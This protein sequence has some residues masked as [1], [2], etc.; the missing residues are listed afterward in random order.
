MTMNPT[1][2]LTEKIAQDTIEIL[3]RLVAFDTT[4]SGSNLQLIEYVE[5]Y[6]ARFGIEGDR[7]ANGSGTKANFIATLGDHEQGGIILSGHSDVVPVVG[8]PWTTPPFE[9][10]ERD[11]RLYGRGTSDMKAFLALS[12]AVVPHL[13]G[14]ALT[15]P[16][17]LAFS[18]DEEVGCL[19][20][21]DL[22]VRLLRRWKPAVAI[23]G[24]PTTMG[25]I[26]GH[27]SIHIYEVLVRGV[28]AHSSLPDH[29]VSANMVAVGLMEVLRVI[30]G[31][32]ERHHRDARFD[33]PWSTLTIGMINGGT[34]SNIL[35]RECRFTFDLRTI[36]AREAETILAPFWAAIDK[37]RSE[38]EK[39]GKGATIE[40]NRLAAV[41]ALGAEPDSEAER[42]CAFLGGSNAPGTAVSYGAEAGYFQQAGISTVICGP[43]SIEQ[44]HRPDE[45][46]EISQIKAGARFMSRL[47]EVIRVKSS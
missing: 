18:Y 7:I 10:T 34:A 46:I 9:L 20:V 36:P 23:V 25:I 15:R 13:A 4:S 30:A 45:Y 29:G 28:E 37:A 47:V 24:E 21:G 27:K 26:N 6:L 14:R 32:E 22:I 38:L 39:Q 33:P 16:V 11:G 5:D 43:G 40:A 42:L 19:G 41:P 2:V 44:A 35:A 8:Q 3:R 31:E 1:E 17:H 12:L